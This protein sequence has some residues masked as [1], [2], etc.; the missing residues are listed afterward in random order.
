MSQ[1]TL[2][3]RQSEIDRNAL[4]AVTEVGTFTL[5]KR[6]VRYWASLYQGEKLLMRC[7][8]NAPLKEYAEKRYLELQRNRTTMEKSDV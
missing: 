7:R 4:V 3:W 6:G 8:R 5:W 1:P 2:Q